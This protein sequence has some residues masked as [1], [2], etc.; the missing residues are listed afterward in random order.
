MTAAAG[1]SSG[2]R[3]YGKYR[4]TV[5]DNLDPLR[6]GRVRVRVP[7]VTGGADLGWAM[8]CVPAGFFSVP[9]IGAEV[10]IEFEQGNPDYPICSGSLW[11]SAAGMPA[12]LPG[13]PDRTVLIQTEGGHQIVLDDTP[14]AAA[15]T[16][17]TAFGQQIVL[18]RTGIEIDDGMG[19]SVRLTARP[20]STDRPR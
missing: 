15:I 5:T 6:I 2:H 1:G 8:P 11:N 9:P 13:Q 19:G 16:F 14:G 17:R 3:L 10:W 18:S 4:G 20:A 12:P 7:E